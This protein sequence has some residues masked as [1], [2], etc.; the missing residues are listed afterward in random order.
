MQRLTEVVL[1]LF[2][3][4]FVLE[5]FGDSQIQVDEDL[6]KPLGA[7]CGGVEPCENQRELQV[8]AC[9]EFDLLVE[10]N[11]VAIGQPAVD[12]VGLGG[13]QG[14]LVRN[15][16]GRDIDCQ[17]IDRV[18][19]GALIASK[20]AAELFQHPLRVPPTRSQTS[21]YRYPPGADDGVCLFLPTLVVGQRPSHRIARHIAATDDKADTLSS[22]L[23]SQLARQRQGRRSGTLRD[24]PCLFHQHQHGLAHFFVGHSLNVVNEL[25]ASSQ[26]ATRTQPAS[27][28]PQPRCYHPQATASAFRGTTDTTTGIPAD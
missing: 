10:I 15:P 17:T 14:T 26:R 9:F 8:P 4:P 18:G 1:P 20:P 12:A 3:I 2:L 11:Q 27:P 22:Q 5:K 6:F 28:A 19:F 7:R 21:T 23:R 13:I 16:A 25:P 24:D